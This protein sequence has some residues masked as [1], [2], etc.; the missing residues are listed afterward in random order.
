MKLILKDIH[1]PLF[2][3]C[4]CLYINISQSKES[5][6][7]FETACFSLKVCTFSFHSKLQ[8]LTYN[9]QNNQIDL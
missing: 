2:S 6:K 8:Q 7:P 3:C 1:V 9:G 5:F 4:S